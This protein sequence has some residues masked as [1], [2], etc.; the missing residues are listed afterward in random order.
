[1]A[2]EDFSIGV[3]IRGASRMIAVPKHPEAALYPSE[4]VSVGVRLARNGGGPR[5]C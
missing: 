5:A 4:I 1:M 2:T 3:C